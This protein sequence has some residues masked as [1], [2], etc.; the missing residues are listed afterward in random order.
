MKYT[1]FYAKRIKNLPSANERGEVN[2]P[3]VFH[4]DSSPSLSI[5]LESGKWKC[6]VPTCPGSK[7]GGY[8]RFDSVLN[9]STPGT[10]DSTEAIDPVIVDGF[11]H[12]LLKN[13]PMLDILQNKRGLTLETIKTHRLGFDSDRVW[14]PILD[15][16][17]VIVN[18]RKYKPG[19]IKDKMI[20]Y[21]PGYNKARL[22][23]VVGDETE[24][25]VLTEGEMDCLVLRQ[26]GFPG[27]TT[28]GG[29][30]TWLEEFTEAL[31]GKRVFICY[32]ADAAGKKASR[33]I[34]MKLVARCPEVR[35]VALPLRGNK[36][37]KDIT[38]YFVDLGHTGEDFE[39]LLEQ[40]EVI[41]NHV[42]E[43]PE[44]PEEI[45]DIHMSEIGEDRLVGRRVRVSLMIAGKDLS[46]FQVPY[47]VA[48]SCEMGQKICAQCGICRNGGTL[49]V[50]IAEYDPRL[51]Q[52]TGVNDREVR[53]VISELAGVPGNCKQFN[54]EVKEH[55]NVELVHAIPEIDF[56]SD[57]SEY[58]LRGL[59]FLG[60]GLETNHTYIVTAVVLPDPKN[61]YATAI[62]YDA[63]SSHDTIERFDFTPDV[64][65]MLNLFQVAT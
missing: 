43:L 34:A 60:S 9:G 39:K 61:Q 46:P 30:D 13:G 63:Q 36:D 23:P 21:A 31:A 54:H 7:G 38:N 18:V 32:D 50:K 56:T 1:E 57:R 8:R 35:I 17:N 12:F 6:H 20:P 62:I 3:C 25:V 19:A 41:A 42:K 65:D 33:S 49:E 5:N 24:W 10:V 58:V 37:E 44:P 53:Q 52:M 64:K 4:K 48:Y 11:H 55:T 59:Y 22:F 27:H 2:I 29:A 40:S 51:I 14:I 47:R 16:S 26:Y 15:S 28:T 45:I